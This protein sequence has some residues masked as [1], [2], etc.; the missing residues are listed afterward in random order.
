MGQR[1]YDLDV[2]PS[3]QIMGDNFLVGDSSQAVIRQG[4]QTTIEVSFEH[5]IQIE[6]RHGIGRRALRDS[7]TAS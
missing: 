3:D 7:E 4:Q 2:L 6:P 5:A 1:V